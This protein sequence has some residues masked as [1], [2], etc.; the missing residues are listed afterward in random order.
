MKWKKGALQCCCFSSMFPKR[1]C[2]LQQDLCNNK[3]FLYKLKNYD[4]CEKR[5]NC[6]FYIP[7]ACWVE[8]LDVFNTPN[9][10][11]VYLM[12]VCFNFFLFYVAWIVLAT[13]FY[14]AWYK[15]VV[16]YHETCNPLITCNEAWS[17]PWNLYSSK[18][19]HITSMY[20]LWWNCYMNEKFHSIIAEIARYTTFIWCFN[21]ISHH[22]FFASC[23]RSGAVFQP[24]TAAQLLC[25]VCSHLHHSFV[26]FFAVVHHQALAAHQVLA[27]AA[28][29][30]DPA[31]VEAAA[32]AQAPVGAV[33]GQVAVVVVRVS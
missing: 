27:V 16:V 5:V 20:L 15:L 18:A 23:G 25:I 21:C 17:I 30:Q 3:V 33:V 26:V 7:L 4:L 13:V 31:V 32:Q 22:C 29:V 19:L 28:P 14:M 8:Y 6:R 1:N 10:P 24:W 11:T 9:L 12:Y 2:R